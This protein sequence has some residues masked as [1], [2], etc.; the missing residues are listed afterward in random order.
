MPNANQIPAVPWLR[1]EDM[2]PHV[3]FLDSVDQLEHL[4]RAE[5]E[6]LQA[7]GAAVMVR[8]RLLWSVPGMDVWLTE[9]A[10]QA[11]Q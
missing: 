4:W 3:S 11:A 9:Q 5:R 7:A 6:S 2:L 10:K 1:T 8:R